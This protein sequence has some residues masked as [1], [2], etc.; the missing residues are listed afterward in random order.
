[1]ATFENDCKSNNAALQDGERERKMIA[2]CYQSLYPIVLRPRNEY[3]GKER[4]RSALNLSQ[5]HA[6]LRGCL[7]CF[8]AVIL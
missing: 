4:L 7:A 2:V 3:Q 8:D 1:M 5:C 6:V